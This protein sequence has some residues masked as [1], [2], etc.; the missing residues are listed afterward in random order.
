MQ[1]CSLMGQLVLWFNF[2]AGF[3]YLIAGVG[4]WLLR[5]WAVRL[6][7]AIAATT[8]LTFAAFGAHVTL[9]GAWEQ[10]TLIAMSLR[11]LVWA[12]IAMVAWRLLAPRTSEGDTQ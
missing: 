5:Y 10:R 8:A 2:V 6:A 4:L 11:T 9:G 7:I 12:G 3:A 1:S